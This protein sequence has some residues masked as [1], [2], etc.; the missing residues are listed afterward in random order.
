MTESAETTALLPVAVDTARSA[1]RT[2]ATDTLKPAADA[3][4]GRNRL[5]LAQPLCVVRRN[6]ERGRIKSI[7]AADDLAA[8]LLT[9]GAGSGAHTPE[10]IT[11]SL[12][13]SDALVDH[14]VY[15]HEL[16]HRGLN[17]STAL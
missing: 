4:N 11:L 1:S 15:L 6:D 8:L 2:A 5:R 9:G 14:V 7:A 3:A 17:D 12:T 13:G 10:R 16:H